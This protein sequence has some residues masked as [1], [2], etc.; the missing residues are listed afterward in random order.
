MQ[1]AV[2]ITILLFS[3][4]SC[5]T[6]EANCI[7]NPGFEVNTSNGNNNIESWFTYNCTTDT[8]A[9]Y[10]GNYGLLCAPTQTGGAI[11]IQE[12]NDFSYCINFHEGQRYLI[13]FFAKKSGIG[14]YACE[15]VVGFQVAWQQSTYEIRQVFNL[16]QE[17]QYY[18]IPFI[19]P[20]ETE[21]IFLAA[22]FNN[23][24]EEAMFD[25]LYLNQV[26]E[27]AS[28]LLLMA[29]FFAIGPYINRNICN[30]R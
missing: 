10:E 3:L 12:A 18:E 7:S 11:F 17:W 13:S 4:I 26:P 30:T 14:E 23:F 5:S 1:K 9:A 2:L 15:A 19:M 22:S 8:V 21:D 24:Q 29:G 25:N 27:P 16:T 28:I 20:L 6:I